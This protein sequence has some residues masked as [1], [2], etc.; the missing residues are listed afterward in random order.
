[1]TLVI[2]NAD[3]DY[4]YMPSYQGKVY[5]GGYDAN[6]SYFRA[7]T[8]ELLVETYVGMLEE[9]S[10][11][12]TWSKWTINT[13][14]TADAEGSAT[15]TCSHCDSVVTVTLPKLD[16]YHL[17]E[18]LYGDAD[19]PAYKSDGTTIFTDVTEIGTAACLYTIN[20]SGIYVFKF[21]DG[22]TALMTLEYVSVDITWGTMSF[23][24]TNCMWNPEDLEYNIGEWQPAEAN[25][26]VI[27]IYNSGTVNVNV[28]FIY[29]SED[30][31]AD[32]IGGSFTG[33]DANGTVEVVAKENENITLELIRKAIPQKGENLS[34]GT[35]TIT[36][37]EAEDAE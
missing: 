9:L 10:G 21:A 13:L 16:K 3:G 27:T 22:T 35:V 14:P 32:S 33:V 17:F 30:A 23:I 11:P 25:A 28:T 4:A 36:I 31:F 5:Y 37:T 24:Y 7:G 26:N 2:T 20:D 1:M 12:H 19:E 29:V 8:A 15:K 34:V 18:D 6:N